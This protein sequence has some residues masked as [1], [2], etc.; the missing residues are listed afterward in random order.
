MEPK[1]KVDDS[2]HLDLPKFEQRA[3]RILNALI[4]Y[5]RCEQMTEDCFEA[6]RST[7]LLLNSIR[8][9]FRLNESSFLKCIEM[10]E[11]DHGNLLRSGIRSIDAF[12]ELITQR[13]N[14]V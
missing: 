5:F 14:K 2:L 13:N 3:V 4:E 6:V 11:V 12:F 9:H 8:M 7:V 10:D 1:I